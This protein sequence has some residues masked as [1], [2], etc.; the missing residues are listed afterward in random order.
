MRARRDEGNGG[1]VLEVL[2]LGLLVAGR[3]AVRAIYVVS[4]CP[5]EPIK[6]L[7]GVGRLP[8]WFL[9]WGGL[10]ACRRGIEARPRTLQGTVGRVSVGLVVAVD[11]VERLADAAVLGD[12]G[13]SSRGFRAGPV[14]ANSVASTRGAGVPPWPSCPKVP[15]HWV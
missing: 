6:V 7:F 8:G 12:A 14:P 5:A 15:G 13:A 1:A 9:G 11:V 10:V 2:S 3:A 4:A